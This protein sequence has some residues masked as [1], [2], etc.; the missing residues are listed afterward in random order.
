LEEAGQLD[1]Q[2]EDAGQPHLPVGAHAPSMHMR[3]LPALGP[4]GF[5]W[6]MG[7]GN[8]PVCL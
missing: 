2:I 8:Q 1:I 5:A 7:V 4:V 3:G 6:L